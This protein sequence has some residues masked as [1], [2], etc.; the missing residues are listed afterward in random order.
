[1]AEKDRTFK[2]IIIENVATI[3]SAVALTLALLWLSGRWLSLLG[4]LL[5]VN[6][7]KTKQTVV[8]CPKCWQKFSIIEVDE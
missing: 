8:K 3:I 7:K 4:L 2:W 1:M 6:L 5:L